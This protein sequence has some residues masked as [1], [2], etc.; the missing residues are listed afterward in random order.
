MIRIEDRLA[1]YERYTQI[2]PNNI[3]QRQ[4]YDHL[5][6]ES[7]LELASVSIDRDFLPKNDPAIY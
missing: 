5:V 1:R 6:D 4:G 3:L 7:N 2:D